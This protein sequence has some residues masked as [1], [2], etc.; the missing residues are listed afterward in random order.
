MSIWMSKYYIPD[1]EEGNIKYIKS[2]QTSEISKKLGFK[3]LLYYSYDGR[4]KSD[5]ELSSDLIKLQEQV[6]EGDLVFLQY[7]LFQ[8]DDRYSLKYIKHLKDKKVLLVAIVWDIPAWSFNDQI[9]AKDDFVQDNLK[10]FDLLIVEN[11][12]MKERMIKLS[13]YQDKEILVLGLTDFLLDQKDKIVAKSDNIYQ[14][15]GENSPIIS[16]STTKFQRI[17]DFISQDSFTGY[18]LVENNFFN[19]SLDLSLYLALGI[20]PLVSS[21]NVQADLIKDNKLGLLY[22]NIDEL[23]NLIEKISEDD[24]NNYKK[25]ISKYSQLLKIGFFMEKTLLEATNN[26]FFK[27]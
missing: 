25:N 18:G 6:Q 16:F 9:T 13:N 10:F 3:D 5:D 14:L 12:I 1:Y 22:E 19:N 2:A 27:K 21:Q 11:E 23:P 7:P 8:D 17:A 15:E 4:D 24:Y 20:P 26:L